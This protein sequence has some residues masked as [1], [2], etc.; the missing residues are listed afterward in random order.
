M[1]QRGKLMHVQSRCGHNRRPL[2]ETA[3]AANCADEMALFPPRRR[4]Q[5]PEHRK[6]QM[7]R[8]GLASVVQK[9]HHFPDWAAGIDR[10]DDVEDVV[11]VA[12]C[13]DD[14]QTLFHCT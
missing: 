7:Y 1:D 13:A 9:T 10:L 14:N 5:R 4:P 12:A 11:G 2:T 3:V 8:A 6:A